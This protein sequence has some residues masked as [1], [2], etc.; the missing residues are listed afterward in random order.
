[1][2]SIAIEKA[3][4]SGDLLQFFGIW[5]HPLAQLPPVFAI[6]GAIWFSFLGLCIGSFLN[7]VIARVP[8]GLSVVKPR[9]R[10][11]KC[12]YQLQWYDNIPIL[13]WLMLGRKCRSCRAP[14]S[15]RYPFVE[16]LVGLFALAISLQFGI[17]LA[18]FEYLFFVAILVSVAF[19]DLDTFTI[20]VVLPSL[21]L[22]EGLSVAALGGAL[23]WQFPMGDGWG[24]LVDRSIGAV[25]GFAVLGAI[26]VISTAI[27]RRSGRLKPDEF[28]M[29]WGDPI[30]L[31]GIGAIL[32]WQQLATVVFLASFQ[33]AVIG[34]ILLRTGLVKQGEPVSETDDWVPP[35]NG[36]P[37]GPFLALAAVEAAFCGPALLD[38]LWRAA[39]VS[40]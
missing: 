25:A 28:A 11:P 29:G 26:L 7:V 40:V 33:G 27:L 30:L 16:L 9:S 35:Q 6:V 39:G 2:E 23:G 20:P 15:F 5:A 14:I 22:V 12:G 4:A 10:C 1:M 19:I 32:G 31:G 8:E 36:V 3:V 24:V 38:W 17:S 37:F 21:L 34:M 18:G 13:S